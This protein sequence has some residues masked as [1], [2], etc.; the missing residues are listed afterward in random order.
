[1]V[2]KGRFPPSTFL[3]ST[4]DAHLILKYL[5]SHSSAFINSPS[6]LIFSHLHFHLRQQWLHWLLQALSVAIASFP[7]KATMVEAAFPLSLAFCSVRSPRM[8]FPPTKSTEGSSLSRF[9]YSF[10]LIVH[11]HLM[12]FIHIQFSFSILKRNHFEKQWN[13]D[14]W[15]YLQPQVPP[16]CFGTSFNF[17][18]VNLIQDLILLMGIET[19]LFF[20]FGFPLCW[21]WMVVKK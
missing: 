7:P 9:S 11:N 19:L 18:N 16:L 8:M 2:L 3:Y 6:S 14:H 4:R 12:K 15:C 1:M 10:L 21:K 5:T 20:S 17:F 13:G